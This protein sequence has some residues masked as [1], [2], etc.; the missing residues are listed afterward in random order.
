MLKW[1]KMYSPY[2]LVREDDPV[3]YLFY[4]SAP[5]IGQVQ[6]D[7]TH[8]ANYGVKLQEHCRSLGLKC[9]LVY[10]GAPEVTHASMADFLTDTLKR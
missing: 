7:P 3:V 2:E 5:A 10:P 4:S 9:E 8:T 6:K 1:I